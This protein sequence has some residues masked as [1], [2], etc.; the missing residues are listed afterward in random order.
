MTTVADQEI[1]DASDVEPQEPTPSRRLPTVHRGSPVMAAV[2]PLA[3]TLVVQ[4][5][6]FAQ[7]NAM[8]E[9]I[10]RDLLRE[11]TDYGSPKKD[12]KPIFPKPS[13]YL[14]GAEKLATVFGLAIDLS[15]EY[16]PEID[17]TGEG[18]YYKGKPTPYIGFTRRC[19][20]YKYDPN[21]GTRLCVG[22]YTGHANSWEERYARDDNAECPNC[23]ERYIR[24]GSDN[25]YCWRKLGGCGSQFPLDDPRVKDQTV[26]RTMMQNPSDIQNT[27]LQIADKRATVKAVRSVTGFSSIFTQDAEDLVAGSHEPPSEAPGEAPPPREPAQSRSAPPRGSQAPQRRSAPPLPPPMDDAPPP[28]DADA[29]GPYVSGIEAAQKV[30]MAPA[31]LEAPPQPPD[32]A[33]P[34]TTSTASSTAAPPANNPLWKETVLLLGQLPIEARRKVLADFEI[35]ETSKA[36]VYRDMEQGAGVALHQCAVLTMETLKSEGKLHA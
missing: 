9:Q 21:T 7:L 11:D 2:N 31:T 5:G 22:Q 27:L 23:H 16:P 13:L 35:P 4:A 14:S 12:G 34:P 29:P 32:P 33:Q 15:D 1:I 28:S 19:R 20:L 25:F 30:A 36:K 6:E 24:R 26:G 18:H 3:P 10:M 8:R 17:L